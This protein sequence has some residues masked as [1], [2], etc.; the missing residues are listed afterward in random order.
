MPVSFDRITLMTSKLAMTRE[1]FDEL[2]EV[3]LGKLDSPRNVHKIVVRGRW[4]ALDETG[5]AMPI[6]I[7]T[8]VREH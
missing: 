7:G 5:E 8:F 3:H 6:Q 4:Y 2:P 1:V